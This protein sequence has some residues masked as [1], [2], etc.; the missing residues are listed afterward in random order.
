MKTIINKAQFGIFFTAGYP[1][2]VISN[3]ND[4]DLFQQ[5]DTTFLLSYS[6]YQNLSDAKLS[7][8][9]IA[10]MINFGFN[11]NLNVLSEILPDNYSGTIFE[12]I[13]NIVNNDI[14]T[15]QQLI[16]M[17]SN[18]YS[19]TNILNWTNLTNLSLSNTISNNTITYSQ[20]KLLRSLGYPSPASSSVILSLMNNGL[21]NTIALNTITYANYLYL[22]TTLYNSNI[23][24]SISTLVNLMNA[25][26]HTLNNSIY[27][28]RSLISTN[29]V[30][31]YIISIMSLSK[32]TYE[33]IASAL[34]NEN[35]LY[36]IRKLLSI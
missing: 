28:D 23:I 20:Y 1:I 19:L 21:S 26:L 4:N 12:N 10:S 36:S 15:V 24:C 6:N 17:L 29:I 5:L 34:N 22:T 14:L 13:A 2:T 3:L 25:G 11:E 32:M 18:G 27:N 8:N 16:Y 31:I 7:D 30:D 35:T 9:I 33:D